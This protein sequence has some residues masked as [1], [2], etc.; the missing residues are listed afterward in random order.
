MLAAVPLLFAAQQVAEGIVWLTVADD[1]HTGL[2]RASVMVFLGMAL[3]VWPLWLPW[4]LQRIERDRARQ[5]MLTVLF[6]FGVAVS[7]VAFVLL[8]RWHPSARIEGHSIAYDYGLRPHGATR[9]ALLVAYVVPT[10]APFFVSSAHLARTIGI[11]LVVSLALTLLV[12]HQTVT[13]VWCFFAAILSAQ[14]LAAVRS[15]ELAAPETNPP[16]PP[17]RTPS[18]TRGRS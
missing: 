5:R 18:P 8:A 10:I 4:S 14:V 12:Q 11:T 16:N 9:I 7:A 2:H 13:S 6:A 3:V 1:A 17:L 15:Q